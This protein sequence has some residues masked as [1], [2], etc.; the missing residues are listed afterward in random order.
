VAVAATDDEQVNT[1]VAADAVARNI[2]VNVVDRPALCTFT[3]PATVCRGD[4]T[5]SVG[6]EERCPALA[7][8]LREEM[9]ER[10]GPEYS[11]LVG[12]FGELRQ[13]MVALAWDGRR[14]RRTLTEVYRNGV[15]ELAAAGDRQRL[16]DFLRSHLGS[17]FPLGR[18]SSRSGRTRAKTGGAR[19]PGS[20]HDWELLTSALRNKLARP[21]EQCARRWAS[22]VSCAEECAAPMSSNPTCLSFRLGM[23]STRWYS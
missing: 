14:I 2:L 19:A 6:A 16:N 20:G 4:L 22:A 23:R 17:P 21:E 18:L 15:I 5:F 8:I 7:G 10:Y 13:R 1:R 11:E 3:V 12:L 9:E